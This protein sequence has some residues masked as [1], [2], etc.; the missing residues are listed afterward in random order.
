MMRLVRSSG[1]RVT[2]AAA[3]GLVA[4][5]VVT[6]STA[7]A[8]ADTL[9]HATYKV[10]G[11]TYIKAAN[12]TLA[13]GPGK[14]ASTLDA[15]TSK[16]TANLT[17][18]NATGSFKQL[19]LIP[20]TATTQFIN[21]GPT[22]GTLNFNTGAVKTTSK[23]TLRIV[24]LSV[25]GLPVPVGNSCQSSTPAVVQVTSQ[26]GFNI[27]KGGNLAGAYTIPQF[28]NCGLATTLINLTIPGPDN[29]ITLTLGKATI[30]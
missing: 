22:T 14:L 23:I 20:V 12:F 4:A 1:V 28:A 3:A 15:N 13:L 16:L 9:V 8:S 29:T 2:V 18:P 10:T 17:L 27:L 26:Q 21:N 11:S 7:P 24:S 6:A 25:G 30:G 19:G 5:G